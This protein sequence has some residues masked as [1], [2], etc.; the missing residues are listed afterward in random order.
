MLKR[1]F[2]ACLSGRHTADR[3][4]SRPLDELEN[5]PFFDDL[6]DLPYRRWV[7]CSAPQSITAPVSSISITAT[8]FRGALSTYNSGKVT[9]C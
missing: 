3:A 5:G 7:W 8:A 4:G 2:T 6:Q 1:V 9:C